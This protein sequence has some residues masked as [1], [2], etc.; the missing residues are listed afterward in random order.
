MNTIRNDGHLKTLVDAV[1]FSI[2]DSEAAKQLKDAKQQLF[3]T[4]SEQSNQAA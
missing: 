1:E 2:N 4:N 3:E